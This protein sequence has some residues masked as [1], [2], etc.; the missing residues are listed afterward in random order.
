MK[1][2]SLLPFV[3]H[4]LLA[5]PVLA[6]KFKEFGLRPKHLHHARASAQGSQDFKLKD[7]YQGQ[8]FLEWV[9]SLVF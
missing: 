9:F 5:G 7:F 2:L 3:L 8:S 6:G 4:L 1:L